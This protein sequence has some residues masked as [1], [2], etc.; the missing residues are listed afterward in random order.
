MNKIRSFRSLGTVNT[1]SVKGDVSNSV[2]DRAQAMVA[3]MD[4]RW[5]LFKDGSEVSLINRSAGITP[6]A[7]SPDTAELLTY[8]R[9]ISIESH[10][11]FSIT[12]GP[13][14][15]VWRSA[16]K[17]KTLPD[18][19]E[20][21]RARRLVSDRSI[22]IDSEMNTVYLPVKGMSIDLGSI[23]KGYA[24]DRI[25]DYLRSEGIND[26]IINF[27]G[28]V[29]VTGNAQRIG[30]QHPRIMTGVPF[31]SVTLENQS[32]V[33]SG[34]YEQGF[35]FRGRRYHHIIDAGTG[36]PC[37]SRLAGVTL[38]GDSAMMMDA[39][40]TAVY[41]A[42]IEAGAPLV[43][44]R[45]IE[46][47]AIIDNMEVICTDNIGKQLRFLPQKRRQNNEKIY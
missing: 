35:D 30:I 40:S 33:T 6:V 41:V 32:A 45:K 10:G 12:I 43:R 42:G 9:M 14:S 39:L 7:V 25:R 34:D 21:N 26:M 24:A 2:L 31:A 17:S 5:S 20:V 11:A 1:I 22:R 46:C 38:I 23:A 4:D 36:E 19:H 16:L 3:D 44:K 28:T 13:L 15:H 27:G 8:A 29:C 37:K 18:Y 47:I